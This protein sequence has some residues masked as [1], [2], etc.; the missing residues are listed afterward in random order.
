MERLNLK[1]WRLMKSAVGGDINSRTLT[2]PYRNY[3]T[4]PVGSADAV[5]FDKFVGMFYAYVSAEAVVPHYLTQYAL[6]SWGLYYLFNITAREKIEMLITDMQLEAGQF[7]RRPTKIARA[8]DMPY[9]TVARAMNEMAKDGLL[10]K[11][12]YGFY[13]M[14]DA[15]DSISEVA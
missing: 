15:N 10:R 2:E 13:Y 12:Q 8:L 1:Q 11:D 9:S 7:F 5:E 4:T 6:S 3:F 14:P